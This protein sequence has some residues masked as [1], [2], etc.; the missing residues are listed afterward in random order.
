MDHAQPLIGAGRLALRSGAW[1]HATRDGELQ[2]S[3][4]LHATRPVREG[5]VRRSRSLAA[6][7]QRLRRAIPVA[8]AAAV[9][10][11]AAALSLTD[12]TTSREAPSAPD[13]YGLIIGRELRG[14]TSPQSIGMLTTESFRGAVSPD[15]RRIAYWEIL[16]AHA[17]ARVLRLTD[18][19]A[20]DGGRVV[21]T[22]PESEAA[23]IAYGS[24]VAW[25]SDGTGLLLAVHALYVATPPPP[26]TPPLAPALDTA[27][28]QV[29]LASGA[30]REIASANGG[31]P[32]QPLG[33]DRSRGVAAAIE[34][35]PGGYATSYIVVREA[36]SLS[37]TRV[38]L[39]QVEV[40]AFLIRAAPDGSRVFAVGRFPRPAVHVW[41]LAAPERRTTLPLGLG[42][43]VSAAMWRNASEIVVALETADAD[44][45][46][47][48]E[49]WPLDGPPRVLVRGLR[50]LDAIRPD[51]TGAIVA[52]HV[53]DL[54][55]GTTGR[56]PLLP[57]V[58]A[59][60]IL[61]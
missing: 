37:P 52:G 47:R 22:L 24:G 43:R 16:S 8:A 30:V 49:L 42:D 19:S 44:S 23:S 33:W 9:I 54:R 4:S 38:P 46:A 13:R 56:I 17:G 60:F 27:L 31:F 29:D 53:V 59:S 35:G 15:G 51:G 7:S 1:L 41:P 5:R 21:L 50:G 61:R 32:V 14:E 58:H 12:L 11:V 45:A 25:S 20:K 57:R 36:A 48:I 34:I 3:P 55:T 10:A 2:S 18:P 26:G 6:R 28:R 40:P 39:D